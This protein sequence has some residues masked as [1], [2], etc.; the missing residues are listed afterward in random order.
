MLVMILEKSTASLRGELSRW[1]VQ[2]RPGVF[3][4]G[5]SKRVRDELWKKACQKNREGVV[6]QVWTS[7]NE[8]GFLY[9]QHGVSEQIWLDF[10]GLGLVVKLRRKAKVKPPVTDGS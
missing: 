1:L 10:E 7:R 3:L 2:V 4:G 6:T 9:R 5:P 8:Q